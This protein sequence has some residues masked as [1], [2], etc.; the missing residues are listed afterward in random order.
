VAFEPHGACEPEFGAPGSTRS[1]LSAFRQGLADAGI[2]DGK[3]ALVKVQ[4]ANFQSQR[5]G[6]LAT[7]LVNEKSAVIVAMGHANAVRAANA[8]T[9]TIPIVFKVAVDPVETFLVDSL[10]RPG[11]NVTGITTLSIAL[12]AKRLDLLRELAPQATTIAY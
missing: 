8:A 3:N 6:T 1:D 7:D 11:G 5:L 10:S 2:I 4:W 9:S 12:A